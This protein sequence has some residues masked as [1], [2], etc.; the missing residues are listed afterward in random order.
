MLQIIGQ[1]L[2][3]GKRMTTLKRFQ[4]IIIVFTSIENPRI[5]KSLMVKHMSILDYALQTL[6]YKHNYTLNLSLIN[7]IP[8]KLC[9]KLA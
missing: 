8:S 9:V 4:T 5:R 3:I 7:I 6:A 1:C 2:R